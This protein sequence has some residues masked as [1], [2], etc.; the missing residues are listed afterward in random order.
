MP[1]VPALRTLADANGNAIDPRVLAAGSVVAIDQ[2]TPGTTNAVDTEL[3]AAA[4]LADA[5]ANP[6]TPS[7]GV[8]L[9]A[10]NGATWDRIR[11]PNIFKDLNAVAIGTITTV[12]TPA[13]GKKFR[14]MGGT[15]SVS[16]AGSVLFEDNAAATTIFRTPKLAADTPYTFD[17]PGG[18]LSAAANNVLKATL[19]VAGNVTGT[20]WGTEE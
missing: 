11:S 6:T 13:S 3:P 17:V 8:C 12:W 16:A 9:L 7:V 19:S 14:L 5:M 10:W 1:Y 18:K 4:V 2:T 15:I 20:L